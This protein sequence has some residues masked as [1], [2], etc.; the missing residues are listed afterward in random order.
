MNCWVYKVNSRRFPGTA[1]WHFDRYFRRPR[2]RPYKMGGRRWIRSPQS[3]ARLR[4]VQ[5]GD[6]FLCYQSDERKIYGLALAAGPGYESLPGS[7]VFDSVD[8]RPGGLRFAVPVPV[9]HPATMAV[10]RNIP[11]FTVPSRG[12]IHPIR[13][14]EL[15]AIIA[16][17]LRLNPPQKGAV[18]E[19]V[20]RV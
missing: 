10:F 13:L 16:M 5:A 18:E 14:D 2:R 7:E 11:A 17:A 15:R 20:R 8:F 6:L 19:F 4:R 9:A 1:G 12:T 3:W